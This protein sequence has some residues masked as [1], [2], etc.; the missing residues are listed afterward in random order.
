[1]NKTLTQIS[2][3]VLAKNEA[4]R[5]GECLRSLAWA[6][7]LIV[8][9]NG[10]SDATIKIAQK[11]KAL[12]VASQANDFSK[13]RNLGKEVAKGNW[14][15][16]V[17]ADER[18]TQSL[19]QEIESVIRDFNSATSPHGYF[20]KRKNFY[21]GH[22]WPYQDKM[23]RLFWKNSLLG[24]EGKL[25]ETAIVDGEIGFLKEPLL[26]YT[27]RTLEEMVEKTNKW[28]VVEAKLR[29]EMNHPKVVWWR[30]VRVMW[31]GFFDSFIRQG[32]WRAGTVAWIESIYQ[33]F[34]LFIT[35][36]KLWELQEQNQRLDIKN[37]K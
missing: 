19:R 32:G 23:Q 7:K 10:S 13:L 30:L 6:D 25:H 1:M 15:L 4:D 8:I 36:A 29:F 28:S 11:H 12:V 26:H 20:I 17:D 5:I 27:H 2:V 14:L 22:P 9:D 33:A 37:Q 16:Y 34:S 21:L 31:T 18:V 24:W 35:Y 3:I